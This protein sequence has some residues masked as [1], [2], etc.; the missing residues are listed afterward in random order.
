MLATVSTLDR[1]GH[2]LLQDLEGLLAAFDEERKVMGERHAAAEQRATQLQSQV[3]RCSTSSLSGFCSAASMHCAIYHSSICVGVVHLILL[4]LT[5]GLVSWVHYTTVLG[6]V[7]PAFPT[8]SLAWLTSWAGDCQLRPLSEFHWL[9]W[10]LYC[11]LLSSACAAMTWLVS[12][13]SWCLNWSSSTASCSRYVPV[14]SRCTH[15]T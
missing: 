10:V 3:R 9:P 8:R 7:C 11:R 6:L 14:L 4:N 15:C 12:T 13:S 1:H 2:V 5:K